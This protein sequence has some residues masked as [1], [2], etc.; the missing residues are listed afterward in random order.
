MRIKKRLLKIA[1]ARKK[2]KEKN[3][4]KDKNKNVSIYSY[5]C[6]QKNIK[7][8]V[9]R[10]SVLKKSDRLDSIFYYSCIFCDK[11][12]DSNIQT[13]PECSRDLVKVNLKKCQLCGAKNN[14]A[15]ESCWVC[16]GP[17]PKL[18]EKVDKEAQLLL[19]LNINNNLYRNTDKIL[20]LG[21][22]KLFEDL[23]SA[24][25]SKEPLEAW[26][27]IHEGEIEYKKESLREE[28]KHLAGESKRSNLM[29]IITLI[30]PIIICLMLVVVF[31]VK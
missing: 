31:W 28:C 20:S 16:N 30:L 11:D 12:F 9:E 29:Y 17:F 21:M 25:F 6:G 14:P 27:K 19:T 10:V 8:T 24:G 5:K 22:R 4:N 23:I 15:K 13:C 2:N 18:E 1:Q 7:L 3:Q 26:V